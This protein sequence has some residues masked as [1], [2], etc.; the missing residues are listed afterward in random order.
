LR[1]FL[2]FFGFDG[3]T[4]VNLFLLSKEDSLVRKEGTF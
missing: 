4:D 2:I 3:S 1:V